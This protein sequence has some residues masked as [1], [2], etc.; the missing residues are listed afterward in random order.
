VNYADLLFDATEAV[1][2]KSYAVKSVEE[3]KSNLFAA[4]VPRL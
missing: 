4:A 2:R 3:K 1:L